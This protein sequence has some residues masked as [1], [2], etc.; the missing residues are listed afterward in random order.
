MP[1]QL[2]RHATATLSERCQ[3]FLVELD[4]NPSPDFTVWVRNLIKDCDRL[5]EHLTSTLVNELKKQRH[6]DEQARKEHHRRIA[7]DIQAIY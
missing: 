1:H 7:R 2:L 4:A 5:E 3:A 6:A